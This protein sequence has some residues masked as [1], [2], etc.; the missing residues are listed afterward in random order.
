MAA[1]SLVAGIGLFM[2]SIIMMIA[3]G[4][5]AGALVLTERIAHQCIGTDCEP[6]R[7]PRAL[8]PERTADLA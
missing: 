8:L 5:F 6:P 7:I 4:F 1:G 2:L 3:I